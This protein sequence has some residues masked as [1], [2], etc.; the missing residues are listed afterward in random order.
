MNYLIL[1]FTILIVLFIFFIKNFL[2]L[3]GIIKISSKS[4]QIQNQEIISQIIGNCKS[5][6]GD[7]SILI[8][9]CAKDYLSK[10]YNYG[11]TNDFIPVSQWDNTSV[12]CK[13]ASLYYKGIFD[14]LGFDSKY[15]VMESINH[16]SIVGWKDDVYCV[17]DQLNI[18]CFYLN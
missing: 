7:E 9:Y 12:D 1:G 6:V 2:S 13:S 17:T 3:D 15:L 10:H 18:E 11:K 16:L 14:E 5:L 4:V 8:L